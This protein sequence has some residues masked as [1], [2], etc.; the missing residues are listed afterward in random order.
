MKLMTQEQAL[1]AA[2]ARLGPL[3]RAW[4]QESDRRA[5]CHLGVYDG[6]GRGGRLHVLGRSRTWERALTSLDLRVRGLVGT[7][8]ARSTSNPDAPT[9]FG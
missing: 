1:E 3:A 9:L 2:R 8:R 4:R 7:H 5:P 6:C